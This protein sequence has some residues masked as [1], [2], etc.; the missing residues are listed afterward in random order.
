MSESWCW[1]L[2]RSMHGRSSSNS[3]YSSLDSGTYTRRGAAV[4]FFLFFFLFLSFFP[5][6]FKDKT[7]LFQV[8][9]VR[10]TYLWSSGVRHR[11]FNWEYV[12]VLIWKS[13]RCRWDACPSNEH[14][15]KG[16]WDTYH[17]SCMINTVTQSAFLYR[18]SHH[19]SVMWQLSV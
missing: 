2:P 19:C 3:K 18:L 16:M 9:I 11:Y 7:H 6:I 12:S 13:A 10:Y 8:L 5:S 14:I 4:S 1:T 15:L 17:R